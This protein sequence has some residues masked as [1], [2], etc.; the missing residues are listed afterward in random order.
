MLL[1]ILVRGALCVLTLIVVNGI[2]L[3]VNKK[4]NPPKDDED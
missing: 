4:I 2:G 1:E 3:W